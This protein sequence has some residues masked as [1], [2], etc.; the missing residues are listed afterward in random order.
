MKKVLGMTFTYPLSLEEWVNLGLFDREKRIYEE[1]LICG[2]FDEVIWFTYGNN[3]EKLSYKLKEAKRLD[4]RIKVVGLPRWAK[5]KI[6][7][8]LYSVMLPIIRTKICQNIDVIKSNQMQGAEVAARIA[9]RFDLPFIFRTGYTFSVFYKK[10]T[11]NARGVERLRSRFWYVIYSGRERELYEKCDM[12]LVSS[13]ADRLYIVNKY[14]IDKKKIE[15]LTNYIDC[16]KFKISKKYN[17]REDRFLFVGRLN[18]QKNLINLVK[19]FKKLNIGID[20]YGIGEMEDELRR[21]ISPENDIMLKGAVPNDELAEIYNNYKYFILPSFFEGM[22]KTLLEAMACGCVCLG[23][24]IEGISEVIKDK[25]NGY[26]IPGVSE[27]AIL[28]VVS[29][30]IMD[31]YAEE[32]AL[33]S[34]NATEKICKNNSLENITKVEHRI[35]ARLYRAQGS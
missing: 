25:E 35:I 8:K 17:D 29:K 22:P 5:G 7:K 15:I 13:K 9:R 21:L 6:L 23:T 31:D 16:D 10:R 30:M 4:D 19:A 34:R 24:D 14:G 3:D 32:N 27:K 20:I 28:E 1:H 18:E 11:Q 2:N 33:I 12:A 26:I